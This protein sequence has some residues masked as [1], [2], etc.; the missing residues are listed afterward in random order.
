M[1]GH[2]LYQPMNVPTGA[3]HH[4]TTPN[5]TLH[6]PYLNA[7][8]TLHL[9]PVPLQQAYNPPAAPT[10]HIETSQLQDPN[11]MIINNEVEP[12]PEPTFPEDDF[13]YY[14]EI[15]CYLSSEEFPHGVSDNYKKHLRKRAQHYSVSIEFREF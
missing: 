13:Q 8:Q 10:V 4:Y 9:A 5:Q 2:T 7:G 14:R 15:Q 6:N 1:S 11:I 3:L 12:S